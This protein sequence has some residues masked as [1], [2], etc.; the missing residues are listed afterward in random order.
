[1]KKFFKNLNIIPYI[2]DGKTY[3]I[4]DIFDID[5]IYS[6]VDKYIKNIKFYE[7]HKL[8]DGDKWESLALK[9]YGN[10]KMF[11]ILILINEMDDPYYDFA[12][13]LREIAR[14]TYYNSLSD[15]ALQNR[16]VNYNRA[17]INNDT[18]REL[19]ILKP[20]YISKFEFEIF[21]VLKKS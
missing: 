8:Q 6:I 10:Q 9:Y 13:T 21:N 5:K 14:A 16:I 18:K 19:R 1:M 4:R 12:L 20:E 11:W 2:I 3:F 15:L 7:V 17:L